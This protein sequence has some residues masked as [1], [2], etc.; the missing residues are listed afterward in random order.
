MLDKLGRDFDG[1]DF[2]FVA[3]L[4]GEQEGKKAG[5][6]AHVCDHHAGFDFTG[7]DDLLAFSKDFPAFGLEDIG[8]MLYVG[9]LE[10]VVDPR[11]DAFFLTEA[12]PLA[13]AQDN[14]RH[15]SA[16]R[17]AMHFQATSYSGYSIP[18]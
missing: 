15:Q 17:N 14:Q 2:P 6:R 8:E 1:I 4:G 10:G 12:A 3:H 9:I 16:S 5:A 11:A 18:P 7:G 13:Q